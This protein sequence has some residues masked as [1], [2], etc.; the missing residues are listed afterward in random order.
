MKQ[1][2]FFFDIDGTLTDGSDFYGGIPDSAVTAIRLLKENG[3]Q[4]AIATGRPYEKAK[5]MAELVGIDCLVCNGGYAC[6]EQ[7]ICLESRG[8]DKKDC[9]H[10]I[11]ECRAAH[12]PFCVSCDDTFAFYSHEE[13]F[14][15]A[16]Q[17]CI[18]RGTLKIL[19]NLNYTKI[20]E[21][22]RILIAL[23]PGEETMI[24]D[25]HSL[26]PMRYHETYVVVEPDD[27]FHGIETMMRHWRGNL[28]D[29]VVFGD[30]LNDVKMFQQAAFSIAMGNAVA[31]LKQEADYVTACAAEDGIREALYHFGWI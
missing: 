9:L 12:I 4:V 15:E 1:K 16:V 19:P 23:K 10:V 6:Y 27:K 3:H 25:Y 20:P 28:Q 5:P 7:D 26:V 22:H 24:R 30:G 13:G 17:P 8:L 29:V 14:L 18:F 31:E 2:Y 11:Q 21:I